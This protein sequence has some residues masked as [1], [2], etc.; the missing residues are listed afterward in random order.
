MQAEVQI[1]PSFAVDVRHQLNSGRLESALDTAASGVRMYPSYMGGYAMLLHAFAALHQ[2]SDAE[3]IYGEITRRFGSQ[4]AQVVLHRGQIETSNAETVSA[5]HQ[6]TV[7]VTQPAQFPQSQSQ[8]QP[9]V[10]QFSPLRIIEFAPRADDTRVIRSSAVRLIPGLEYT[11][12]RYE[13][14]KHRGHRSIQILGEPPPFREFHPQRT[15]PLPSDTAP[16]RKLSL[17]EL[18]ERIGKVRIKPEDSE[19]KTLHAESAAPHKASVVTET[20][21]RIY[22]TQGNFEKA[23]EAFSVLQRQQ[24]QENARFQTLIDECNDKLKT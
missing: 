12:L 10:R 20:L 4:A 15:S 7:D 14:A 8:P 3:V 18:A 9:V 13:G 1:R 23:I 22:M 2:D 19:K 5:P 11:S 6:E 24:P 17:E 16:Q 21:A